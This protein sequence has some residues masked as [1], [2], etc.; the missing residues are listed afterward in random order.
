MGFAIA[1][2]LL[3]VTAYA[4]AGTPLM[5]AGMIHLFI[6]NAIIGIAEGLLLGYFFKTKKGLSIAV[7]ILAN[8]VS[9]WLGILALMHLDG[10]ADITLENVFTWHLVLVGAAYLFTVIIELPFIR[11]L[12]RKQATA[13]RKAIIASFVINTISYLALFG[14]Y[15]AASPTT[16]MTDFEV[17]PAEAVTVRADL[18]L[19]Y[20]EP[21]GSSIIKQRM[22]G[23]NRE[24][25]KEVNATH[26]NDRVF[27]KANDAGGYDLHLYLED[28]ANQIILEDFAHVAPIEWR[29]AEGHSEEPSETHFNFGTVPR[30]DINP[31]WEFD[32]GFWAASGLTGENETTGES[33][34]FAM[35]SPLAGWT[36]RNAT[37]LGNGLVVFQCGKDQICLLDAETKQVALMVRG[38]GPIVVVPKSE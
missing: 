30:L 5:W 24:T 13:W 19:Y 1:L 29:V 7:M 25:I 32:T 27:A 2:G 4:N 34:T 18:A 35:E 22:D 6:G 3:P 21:D 31:T 9:A 12:F 14:W 23:G 37:S 28:E 11:V 36:I 26:R 8:Y 15:A 17:V 33:I 20:I 38:K 10:T 16:A